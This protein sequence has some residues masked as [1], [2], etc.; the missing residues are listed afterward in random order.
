MSKLQVIAV[1]SD[2]FI[3]L[4]APVVIGRSNYFGT[5]KSFENRS[6]DV[7][8]DDDDND[9]EDDNDDDREKSDVTLITHFLHFCSFCRKMC[10][11]CFVSVC[12][13][14]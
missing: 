9:C 4:F 14:L 2:W 7:S 8:D 5:G 3:T 11:T 10:R 12:L 13:L 6:N 1:K